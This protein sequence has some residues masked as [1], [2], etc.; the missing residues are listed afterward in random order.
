MCCVTVARTAE[1][2]PVFGVFSHAVMNDGEEAF[3]FFPSLEQ[4][5]PLHDEIFFFSFVT[6]EKLFESAATTFTP[7]LRF[8]FSFL[9]FDVGY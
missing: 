9:Q 3:Q 6:P 2:A 7:L 4:I 5:H 8:S 1:A